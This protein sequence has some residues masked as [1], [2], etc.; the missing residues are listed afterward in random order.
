MKEQQR[1][2]AIPNVLFIRK[3]IKV[4]ALGIFLLSKN[5]DYKAESEVIND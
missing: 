3:V 4:I 1:N 5:V 2:V